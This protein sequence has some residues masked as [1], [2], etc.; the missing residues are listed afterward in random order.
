MP[1]KFSIRKRIQSFKYAFHGIW[2]VFKE[3][4]NAR[5]HL[6]AAI[7]AILLGWGL[8]ISSGEWLAILIVIAMVISL[9]MMNSAIENLADFVSTDKHELLKKAK[10]LSA[11]AVLWSAIIA[12]IVGGIVFLP[13]IYDWV[14]SAFM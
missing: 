2:L 5:I 13:K 9:E 11:G 3:E 4:H 14:L 6:L 12:L 10:D 7:M 1:N 8:D